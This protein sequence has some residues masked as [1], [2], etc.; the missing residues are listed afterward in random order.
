MKNQKKRT[1][2]GGSMLNKIVVA[3]L[4]IFLFSLSACGG[5]TDA[6]E[7]TDAN[8]ETSA[9]STEE[10]T[11]PGDTDAASDG[12]EETT[13]VKT[14]YNESTTPNED[15]NP[16][17]STTSSE[18]ENPDDEDDVSDADND[19]DWEDIN[20]GTTEKPSGEIELPKVEF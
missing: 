14:P 15:K 16:T 10:I 6:T 20:K 11:Q 7:T 9:E 4:L 2:M 5:G 17:E 3:L 18:D 19:V 13:T 12:S 8:G 1:K